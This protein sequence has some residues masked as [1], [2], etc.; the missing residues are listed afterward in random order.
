MAAKKEEVVI[1]DLTGN[2]LEMKN[3]MSYETASQRLEQIVNFKYEIKEY[4]RSKD[5]KV[6]IKSAKGLESSGLNFEELPPGKN[7]FK[8]H[9]DAVFGLLDHIGFTLNSERNYQQAIIDG[10]DKLQRK[11]IYSKKPE[12]SLFGIVGSPIGVDLIPPLTFVQMIKYEG[13]DLSYKKNISFDNVIKEGVE[14]AKKMATSENDNTLDA[15][16]ETVK[17]VNEDLEEKPKAKPRARKKL[18]LN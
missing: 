15:K 8:T 17:V 5:F 4:K 9:E 7:T 10:K 6:K 16:K 3:Q 11:V 18:N 14:F 2:A 13:E 1:P 12:E